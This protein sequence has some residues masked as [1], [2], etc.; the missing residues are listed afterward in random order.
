MR[1][2]APIALAI[3]LLFFPGEAWARL[4]LLGQIKTVG[5]ASENPLDVA[6]VLEAC[7]WDGVASSD[8][9]RT[10][11]VVPQ[12]QGAVQKTQPP[13]PL[14]PLPEE[15]RIRYRFVTTPAPGSI[16]GKPQRLFLSEDAGATWTD[17]SPWRFLGNVIHSG[18]E[19]DRQRFL[20]HYGPLLPQD[21]AWPWVFGATAAALLGIGGWCCRRLRGQCPKPVIR[22]AMA[23]VL[24]GLALFFL[25]WLLIAYL[26]TY[27]WHSFYAHWESGVMY[28]LWA[29]GVFLHLTGNARLAPLM[30]AALFPSTALCASILFAAP[31]AGRA[32][33]RALAATVIYGGLLIMLILAGTW[34][35]GYGSIRRIEG[36]EIRFPDVPANRGQPN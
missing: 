22:S 31:G 34:N 29:R 17:V 32:W 7:E 12:T 15:G 28:P 27:Q 26:C 19:A 2:L 30:A 23:Y 21:T 33:F 10:W 8:G 20:L 9:G 18:V 3:W 11:R 16:F 25:H 13:K 35:I 6:I 24:T 5:L 1:L 14:Y 4:R 36:S